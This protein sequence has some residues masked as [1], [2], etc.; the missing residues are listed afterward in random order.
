MGTGVD[1]TDFLLSIRDIEFK[2]DETAADSTADVFFEGPYAIDLL[3]EAGPL[4]QSLGETE[5]PASTYQSIRLKLHKTREV[6]PTSPLYDRSI[7]LAGTIDGTPFEMWHDTGENL[8]IGEANGI[9]VGQFA[10]TVTVDFSL[11][12]FLDQSANAADGGVLIDLSTATDGDGDGLIEINPNSD[13]G[14]IN[15]DLADALKDNIKLVADIVD[16]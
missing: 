3:D 7:F 9:E 11:R 14:Q 5:V 15:K 1:V 13:D 6:D 12:S 2:V 16:S 8:D 10:T 4:T